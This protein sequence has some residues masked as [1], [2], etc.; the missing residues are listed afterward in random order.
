VSTINEE[1]VLSVHVV[2]RLVFSGLIC[3]VFSKGSHVELPVQHLFV[4]N[5]F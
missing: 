3:Y 4:R 1:G 2:H 5:L